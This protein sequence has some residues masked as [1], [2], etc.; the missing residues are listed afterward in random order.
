M[1]K[2]INLNQLPQYLQ[3]PNFNEFMADQMD[4]QRQRNLLH[5]CKIPEVFI[6]RI[7]LASSGSLAYPS[8]TTAVTGVLLVSS[9]SAQLS[10]SSTCDL[11]LPP[12]I[13]PLHLQSLP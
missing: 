2:V 1:G 12:A 13:A 4:Q 9:Y 8:L 11:S 3:S 7:F 10:P 6:S 5:V